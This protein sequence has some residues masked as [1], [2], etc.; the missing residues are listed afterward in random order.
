M[1]S[2]KVEKTSKK[3][4]LLTVNITITLILIIILAFNNYRLNLEISKKQS[5]IL[6]KD[7]LLEYKDK[8]ID[9]LYKDGSEDVGYYTEPY[10]FE[11][12]GVYSPLLLNKE[13]AVTEFLYR[14]SKAIEKTIDLTDILTDEQKSIVGPVEVN[15]WQ[16]P[17]SIPGFVIQGYENY[18]GVPTQLSEIEDEWDDDVY[19][20][21]NYGVMHWNYLYGP[22]YIAS[23]TLESF[24]Q[25]S[26]KGWPFFIRLSAQTKGF[27]SEKTSTSLEPVK[28]VLEEVANTLSNRTPIK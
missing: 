14:K 7:T 4:R 22:K 10:S 13:V 28:Q 5:Q 9:L 27:P 16:Y 23:V 19:R 12:F 20:T 11:S 2:E 17:D 1:Q 24:Q 26:P 25:T 15:I 3:E 8:E 21:V 6:E 18:F